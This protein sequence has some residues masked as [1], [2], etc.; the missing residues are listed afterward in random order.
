MAA[1]NDSIGLITMNE[2]GIIKSLNLA[3]EQIFGYQTSEILGHNVK[4]LIPEIYEGKSAY[5]FVNGLRSEHSGNYSAWYELKG[6]RKNGISFPLEITLNEFIL[7]ERRY[8]S[9]NL[10]DITSRRH[11]EADRKRFAMAVESSA[12]GVLI[13]DSDG[14][15]EYVNPV[16]THITG[17]PPAEAVGQNIRTFLSGEMPG[18]FVDQMWSAL[19]R[20]EVW[21]GRLMNRR[22]T[23]LKLIVNRSIAADE[24]IYWA[25][26]TIAPIRDEEDTPLGYVAV[27][28]DVTE[29]V[30]NE[31]RQA[32]ARET[33]NARAKISQILLD[34]RP[35]RER[36]DDALA[37]LLSISDLHIQSKGGLFIRPPG[38]DTIDMF[39]MRGEFTEDFI[40]TERTIPVGECLC[41][42]AA[43]SGE[44]LISDDCFCD[45]RHEHQ[46]QGM[47]N[48][49]HYI[50]P[51]MHAGENL[52]VLFLYTDPYPSRDPS[53]LEM[54]RLV[55]GMM[56]MA[57]ANERMQE[58]AQQ[59][60]EQALEAS[61]AKSEFL[62]NM[63]HE[64]RTPMNAILGMTE[65]ALDSEL[66]T[67][68]REYLKSVESSS[69]SLLCLID[70]ILDFSKIEAGQMDIGEINFDLRDVVEGIAD[71][72]SIQANEKQI[73]LTC[74]IKP[75]LNTRVK[76][77]AKR[78]RQ[79]LVNLVGN[80][81]KFTNEGEVAIKVVP[82][83]G[84]DDSKLWLHFVVS[85]TGIGI[86]KTDQKKIFDKFSQ[87]DSSST[88]SFGGTGLGLSI[89]K[90]L[91][92]L[93]D[94]NIWVV[95]EEGRGSDFHFVL[96]LSHGKKVE[97]EYGT[98]PGFD[99][100]SVLIVDDN[101]TNRFIL[102]K[103]LSTWGCKV[104]LAN[105]GK[106]ALSLLSKE[107]VQYDLI[108][109][110]HHMPEMD[111]IEVARIIKNELN[112]YGIKIIMLSSWGVINYVEMNELGIQSLLTKPVKQSRLFNSLTKT[113]QCEAEEQ[114]ETVAVQSSE[115]A[116]DIRRLKILLVEDT[117]E[118]QR[119]TKRV[120]QKEGFVVD[121][122]DNGKLGVKAARNY[123]YDLILMDVQMPLMD[124][125]DATRT[126][127]AWEKGNKYDHVPIIALTAHATA[128]YR[129]KCIEC[130]MDDYVTK[131][132]NKQTLLKAIDKWIDSRPVI[133]VA[134]DSVE[135]RRLIQNNLIKE[136]NY[137]VVFAQN[138]QEAMETYARRTISLVLMDI[139]MPVMDGYRATTAIRTLP[140]GVDVPIIAM[141][142]HHG[143]SEINK[144]M[145][146][147][148]SDYLAKPIRKK[149]LLEKIQTTLNRADAPSTN[150]L[151]LS[152]S[153]SN[154][155]NN[156]S[157]EDTIYKDIVVYV[158]PDLEDLIPS[159][160]EKR[161]QDVAKIKKLLA[162]D[163]ANSVEEIRK[164]GH[165]MKGTGG[166]YGFNEISRIGKDIE[167]AANN[168]NKKEIDKL[169]TEL[170]RYIAMVKV[171]TQQK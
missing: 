163:D 126:I 112:I 92:E 63:S 56:G 6:V 83:K 10:R 8:V 15:I 122:V 62:A 80:A 36:F 67:E 40:R 52:G 5:F 147:G 81:V 124:G 170:S 165:S 14:T 164:L 38:S 11:R 132:I 114:S 21:K 145:E 25:Q 95:S 84:Q 142:A 26:L 7:E 169:N 155:N 160:I 23:E 135:N 71:M 109:L 57:I 148:C 27:Q 140:N 133:L 144:C 19:Q 2:H 128:G 64:I 33:A 42:R 96:P 69:E 136:N 108:L 45:P 43:A 73:E 157:L 121:I 46:Y 166:G 30:R 154:S 59:A 75:E 34:R 41:G 54:L 104:K 60:R 18:K 72:L 100:L 130:G 16:M 68:Q 105:S 120:L 158:D 118:S 127:R 99:N 159:F 116:R 143:S 123:Q 79:I 119:L 129:E 151:A 20:G 101:K 90:A 139:E 31:E 134:D 17:W 47:V 152:E 111:G 39:L 156:K 82:T 51:L 168:N 113:L 37:H 141:T 115:A 13:A 4:M 53:R 9:C 1:N 103:I 86:S 167:K 58:E 24:Y 149:N 161:R 32:F 50:V 89:S 150:N 107:T 153:V 74:Y 146:A 106:D 131:P 12:E 117:L 70:D 66:S 125:F 49:G 137:K 77:D 162:I 102:N 97:A 44:L 22:K 65:L 98:Y 85:D 61:K 91:V 55:G 28:R 171:L 94:G 29:E 110:D 76:G 93:M 138:G 87:V 35:L 88:R 3:T 48:H 78:L